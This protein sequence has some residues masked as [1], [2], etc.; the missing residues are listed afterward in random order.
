MS[1]LCL[2]PVLAYDI[3]ELC[4][5]PVLAYDISELEGQ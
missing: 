1:N 4:L 2:Q 3:S 5:Q